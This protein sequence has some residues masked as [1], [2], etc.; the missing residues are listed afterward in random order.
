MLF[1]GQRCTVAEMA[2]EMDRRGFEIGLHP[3][4][5][6]C[7]DADELKRQ[8]AALEKAVGK[9]VMSVRQHFLRYDI[10]VTPASRRGSFRTTHARVTTTWVSART[11]YPFRLYDGEGTPI[12]H[13]GAALPDPGGACYSPRKGMRLTKTRHSPTCG[14][15]RAWICRRSMTVWPPPLHHPASM[16]EPLS[17]GARIPEHEGPVGRYRLR[18]RG[19]LQERK[20]GHYRG[21]LANRQVTPANLSHSSIE[22]PLTRN[23]G[24]VT[25][26]GLD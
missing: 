17:Q 12:G 6:T 16:L 10:R 15:R 5:H 18:G 19:L 14:N 23:A 2:R 1:E 11:S 3:S 4:W 25:L 9:E 20:R 22:K 8:K 7:G 21:L 13:H 24:A 26:T